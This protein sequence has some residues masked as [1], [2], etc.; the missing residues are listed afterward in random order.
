MGHIF[1]STDTLNHLM[2]DECSNMLLTGVESSIQLDPTALTKFIDVL[3]ETDE[4]LFAALIKT[5]SK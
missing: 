2:A 1:P 3:R 5:I 4:N